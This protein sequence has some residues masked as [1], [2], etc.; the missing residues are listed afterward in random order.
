[1]PVC[2]A[3]PPERILLF[4]RW[5][6]VGHCTSHRHSAAQSCCGRSTITGPL[7]SSS[8]TARRGRQERHPRATRSVLPRPV[9][10]H[11]ASGERARLWIAGLIA[12]LRGRNL[13]RDGRWFGIAYLVFYVDHGRNATQ[14]TTTLRASIRRSLP[15]VRSHGSIASRS[16]AKRERRGRHLCLSRL[17][18]G[19]HRWSP[20]SLILPMAS[21]DTSAQQ[22][23]LRYTTALH[24]TAVRGPKLPT[25][26]PLPQFY[27]DRFGW[28]AASTTS[29]IEGLPVSSRPRN[30]GRVCIF[31]KGLWRKRATS[32]SET[33]SMHDTLPA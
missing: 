7:L 22:P 14:R 31:G 11:A 26:G 21:P 24:L 18:D 6:A 15:L 29:V 30:R 13:L 20:G 3:R 28:D 27:A 12:L 16:R 10:H 4:T 9:H 8:K 5:A 25:T 32:T 2:S 1:M 33:V 17:R 19:H 23:G